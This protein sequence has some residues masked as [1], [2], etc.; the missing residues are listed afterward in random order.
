MQL[1]RFAKGRSSARPRMLAAATAEHAEHHSDPLK[2]F[3]KA[4]RAPSR[5]D[6][7]PPPEGQKASILESR[8]SSLGVTRKR[9][10]EEGTC[11]NRAGGT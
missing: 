11:K 6:E 3:V 10:G 2:T 1:Y 8:G 4:H 7:D 5:G 9:H